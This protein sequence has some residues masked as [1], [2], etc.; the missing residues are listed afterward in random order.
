MCSIKLWVW[1]TIT[2]N[3][4]LSI[5]WPLIVKHPIKQDLHWCEQLLCKMDSH[6]RLSKIW[7]KILQFQFCHFLLYNTFVISNRFTYSHCWILYRTKIMKTSY[8]NTFALGTVRSRS[9]QKT[10]RVMYYCTMCLNMQSATLSLSICMRRRFAQKLGCHH[11]R[12]LGGCVTL[13]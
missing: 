13:S 10:L 2:L 5:L 4:A 3:I 9:D 8:M 6:G 1:A 12:G 7:R 11:K